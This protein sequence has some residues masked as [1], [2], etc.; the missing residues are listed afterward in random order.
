MTDAVVALS[1]NTQAGE[2]YAGLDAQGR[3]QQSDSA[4]DSDC[5]G[6]QES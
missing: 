5:G 4:L 1:T 2:Y 3:P 6:R